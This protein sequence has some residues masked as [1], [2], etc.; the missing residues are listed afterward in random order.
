MFRQHPWRAQLA[1]YG[2][3][4]LSAAMTSRLWA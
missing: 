2:T 4:L 1:L 3:I